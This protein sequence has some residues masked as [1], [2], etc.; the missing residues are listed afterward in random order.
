MGDTSWVFTIYVDK[1]V[2]L[3]PK[4]VLIAHHELE[5]CYSDNTAHC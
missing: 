5:N 4:L 1:A 3:V 2:W